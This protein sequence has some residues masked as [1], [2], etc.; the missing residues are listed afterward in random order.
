LYHG[1]SKSPLVSPMD[2]K[3]AIKIVGARPAMPACCKAQLITQVQPFL[4]S[5]LKEDQDRP[6]SRAPCYDFWRSGVTL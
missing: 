1:R 2:F 4:W 5:S 3:F 6:V